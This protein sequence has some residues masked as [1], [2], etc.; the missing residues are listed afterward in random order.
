MAIV[1]WLGTASLEIHDG[2]RVLLV[3]PHLSRLSKWQT[4]TRPIEPD[5]AKIDAY[6]G[7]WAGEV[8]G[9]LVT[10]AHSDHVQDVPYIAE[11]LGVPVWGNESVDTLLRVHGLAGCAGVLAGGERFAVGPFTVEAIK[12]RHGLVA[13][14]RAPFPGT[15]APTRRPPL[16][17]WHYRHGEPPLLA[18]IT[19][20]G[21]TLYHQGTANLIDNLLPRRAVDDAWICVS[22]HQYTPQFLER[23]L[24]RIRP[25][26]LLPFHFEDFSLPLEVE[27]KYIPGSDPHLFADK[28]R[29]VA[30]EVEVRIPRPGEPIAL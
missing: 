14:G 13:F 3:D 24:G 15:I 1:K 27:G 25:R 12:T 19:I 9:I 29:R 26:R 4:F 28:V 17:V 11:R 30:P 6:L 16:W 21:K 10:H 22:G 18:L 5:R 20:G 8:V 7:A 23:L 2:D